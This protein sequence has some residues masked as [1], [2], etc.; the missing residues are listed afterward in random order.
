[1]KR[2]WTSKSIIIQRYKSI[3]ILGTYE[4]IISLLNTRER[5]QTLGQAL[6]KTA[7]KGPREYLESNNDSGWNRTGTLGS[8][9]PHLHAHAPLLRTRVTLGPP[10]VLSVEGRIYNREQ[11]RRGNRPG[12]DPTDSTPSFSSDHPSRWGAPRGPEPGITGE[13][14]P[15]QKLL[16]VFLSPCARFPLSSCGTNVRWLQR[17]RATQFRMGRHLRSGVY[18]TQWAAGAD[19]PVHSSTPGSRSWNQNVA[20]ES[21]ELSSSAMT[22]VEQEAFPVPGAAPNGVDSPSR[23]TLGGGFFPQELH[24]NVC[25]QPVGA[26]CYRHANAALLT[27]HVRQGCALFERKNLSR[28]QARICPSDWGSS[29]SSHGNPPA[30]ILRLQ[31]CLLA[32]MLCLAFTSSP[33]LNVTP[34]VCWVAL[35]LVSDPGR[36]PGACGLGRVFPA[37]IN[38]TGGLSWFIDL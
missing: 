29:L 24:A 13:E 38:G 15:L 17:I 21:W 12:N 7:I 1:M 8:H 10:S 3:N 37:C 14:D 36:Q 26:H 31:V 19:A 22:P 20:M 9:R 32:A 28:K 4:R 6:V 23:F 35:L 25:K 33:Y 27:V 2:T 34:E 5:P 11:P 16:V 18:S 30:S